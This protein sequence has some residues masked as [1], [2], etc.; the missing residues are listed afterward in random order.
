MTVVGSDE[1]MPIYQSKNK[2]YNFAI[3]KIIISITFL[4]I[5]FI[6]Q[7]LALKIVYYIFSF[8]SF[9]FLII[10]KF[11]TN[12][13]KIMLNLLLSIKNIILLLIFKNKLKSLIN[14]FY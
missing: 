9:T 13:I 5:S 11:F 3:F 4:I 14:F 6:K 7:Y 1:K 12:I 8:L 2:N 10:L